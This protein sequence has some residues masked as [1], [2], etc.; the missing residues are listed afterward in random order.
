MR[1]AYHVRELEVYRLMQLQKPLDVMVSHDWPHGIA[2]YGNLPQLLKRKEFLR[3]DV[4]PSLPVSQPQVPTSSHCSHVQSL[5]RIF[6]VAPVSLLE[7]A[8]ICV[9]LSVAHFP[10]F[11]R[12]G[13]EVCL[14]DT[15]D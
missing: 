13:R 11:N 1:S 9:V 5:Q 2:Y 12:V 7:E 8:C 15:A 10:I 3:E 6:D 4:S 14:R